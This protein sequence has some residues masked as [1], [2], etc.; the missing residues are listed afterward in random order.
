M[1]QNRDIDPKVKEQ[2]IKKYLDSAKGRRELGKKLVAP[3]RRSMDY[4]SIARKAFS[5][6][7]L[8]IAKCPECGVEIY[9]EHPDNGCVYGDVYNVMET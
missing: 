9:S 2:I 5:V 1:S 6:D 4:S 7:P 3:L 8:P